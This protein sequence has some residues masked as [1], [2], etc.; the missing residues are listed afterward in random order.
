MPN[1]TVCVC[2][3]TH[4]FMVFVFA[5]CGQTDL[6]LNSYFLRCPT[7]VWTAG[8]MLVSGL[9]PIY[10]FTRTIWLICYGITSYPLEGLM[11]SLCCALSR[12]IYPISYHLSYT[13][14]EHTHKQTQTNTNVTSHATPDT[15]TNTHLYGPLWT[16]SDHPHS[17]VCCCVYTFG[18]CFVVLSQRAHAVC[19]FWGAVQPAAEGVVCCMPFC[20]GGG[21]NAAQSCAPTDRPTMRTIVQTQT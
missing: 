11:Y 1:G 7:T 2:P 5:P 14:A 17:L 19:Q 4:M 8:W 9:R 16:F 10:A 20:C 13:H 6:R 15:L 12:L 3:Q 21:T 18:I